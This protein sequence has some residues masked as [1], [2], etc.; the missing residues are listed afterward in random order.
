MLTRSP[1]DTGGSRATRDHKLSVYPPLRYE[2]PVD[3]P[4]HRRPT[5]FAPSRTRSGFRTDDDPPQVSRRPTPSGSP[6]PPAS[7]SRSG[8]RRSRT[9]GC[10][11]SGPRPLARASRC[12]A[13]PRFDAGER[14]PLVVALEHRLAKR[15]ADSSLSSLVPL[16]CPL[17]SSSDVPHS[18]GPTGI[19]TA[20]SVLVPDPSVATASARSSSAS[21]TLRLFAFQ[22]VSTT[23]PA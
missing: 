14:A 21:V 7:V 5:R 12:R 9:R 19:S 11:A 17:V 1:A 3:R 22:T 16:D 13:V 15:V 20:S 10:R 4:R 8:R 2:R 23:V 18:A 6:P